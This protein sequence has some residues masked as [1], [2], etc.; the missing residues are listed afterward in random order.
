MIQCPCPAQDTRAH[1]ATVSGVTKSL[2]V[3]TAENLNPQLKLARIYCNHQVRAIPPLSD[4]ATI[5]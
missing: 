1:I 4:G 5:V 3:R 2:F